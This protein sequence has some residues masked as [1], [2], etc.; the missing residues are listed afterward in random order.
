MVNILVIEKWARYF[1]TVTKSGESFKNRH[2]I[3]LSKNQPDILQLV[4][5]IDPIYFAVK[6]RLDIFKVV[7]KST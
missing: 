7:Q 5:K 2:D 3:L 1:A 6:N 4:Q